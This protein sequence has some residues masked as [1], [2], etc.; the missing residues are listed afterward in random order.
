MDSLDDILRHDGGIVPR[1]RYGDRVCRQRGPAD[2]VMVELE[3]VE[4]HRAA[5][6]GALLVAP[7]LG[8]YHL[9]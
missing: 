8:R 2:E 3:L 5:A 9:L 6:P 7:E 1:L 4:Q